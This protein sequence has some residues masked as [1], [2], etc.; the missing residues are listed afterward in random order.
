MI[1][2]AFFRIR[3]DPK[4]TLRRRVPARGAE[5]IKPEPA[6]TR[7][8]ER[9]ALPLY[10]ARNGIRSVQVRRRVGVPWEATAAYARLGDRRFAAARDHVENGMTN[11][12]VM[13]KYAIREHRARWN[14][15]AA[16]N[17]REAGGAQAEAQGQARGSKSKPKARTLTREQ[18]LPN[19][20][21]IEAGGRV[22]GKTR[23]S[24]AQKSRGASE[25][26]VVRLLRR[27][28]TPGSTTSMRR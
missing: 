1:D 11:T 4:E 23:A 20:S 16:S 15:G 18:E 21:P 8:P 3:E 9:L 17:R 10:T 25:A 24:A 14:A 22:P 6:G 28:G 5:L 27:A 12:E 7:S 26:P 13:A 19:R 2:V